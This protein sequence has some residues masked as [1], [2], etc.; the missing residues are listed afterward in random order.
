MLSLLPGLGNLANCEQILDVQAVEALKHALRTSHSFIDPFDA[1]VWL[2]DMSGRLQTHI[3]DTDQRLRLLTLIHQEALQAQ[4]S[5]ELVLAVIHV[6]SRFDHYALSVAGARGL[7]QV[8]PFWKD[9][10]GRSDDNLFDIATNLRYGCAIL[11][12]YIQRERGNL[13]RA[14]ARYNGSLGSLR[15][16]NKVM[17]AWARYWSFD[18]PDPIHRPYSP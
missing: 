5:P 1:Q 8:M 9:E 12:H 14:L 13:S 16:P 2:V 10:L 3:A 17:D 6:E 11:A 15:Y 7:M 4:V 18:H